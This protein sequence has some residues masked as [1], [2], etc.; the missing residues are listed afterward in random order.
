[1]PFSHNFIL[2]CVIPISAKHLQK[3]IRQHNKL[4]IRMG[5]AA[6]QTRPGMAQYILL[7]TEAAR[8]GQRI[9]YKA[10][11]LQG[12]LERALLLRPQLAEVA[13]E[14]LRRQA[15]LHLLDQ[16]HHPPDL[17]HNTLRQ[18]RTVDFK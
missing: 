10:G 16:R 11:S 2:L 5:Q 1:M 4:P 6:Q 8:A 3:R 17:H 14:H 13:L 7:W 9:L 18:C 12:R 15:A